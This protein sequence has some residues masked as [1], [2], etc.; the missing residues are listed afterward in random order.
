MTKTNTKQIGGGCIDDGNSGGDAGGGGKETVMM[1]HSQRKRCID[2]T[3]A[4]GPRV[5]PFR[6][7]IISVEHIWRRHLSINFANW[8]A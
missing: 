5:V 1:C 3:D 8:S 7:S 2:D 4:K 6:E